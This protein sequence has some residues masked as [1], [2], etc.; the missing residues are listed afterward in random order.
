[1]AQPHRR[2][3]QLI[4]WWFNDLGHLGKPCRHAVPA[5]SSFCQ[6]TD[7]PKSLP[8]IAKVNQL[9]VTDNIN[10]PLGKRQ[11]CPPRHTG[12]PKPFLNA[13]CLL[14]KARNTFSENTAA[15]AVTHP[16]ASP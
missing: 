3:S 15:K 5:F 7:V 6:V 1:M 13:L 8:D 12:K 9:R 14:R 11:A 16:S 10:K 2:S 4:S